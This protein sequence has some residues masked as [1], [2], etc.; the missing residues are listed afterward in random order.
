MPWNEKYKLQEKYE[1]ENKD[2]FDFVTLRLNK[3]VDADIIK[4]IEGS[5]RGTVLKELIRK[6]LEA[7]SCEDDGK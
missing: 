7:E 3:E 2:K 4:R 1:K 5:K 6:G